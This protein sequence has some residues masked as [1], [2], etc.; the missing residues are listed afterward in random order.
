MWLEPAVA[1]EPTEEGKES[2]EM[3]DPEEEGRIMRVGMPCEA[4]TCDARQNRVSESGRIPTS[5]GTRWS[6][7]DRILWILGYELSQ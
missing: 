4:C 3:E 5:W 6:C 7:W 2:L 1:F